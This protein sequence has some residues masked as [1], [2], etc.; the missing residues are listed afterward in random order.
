MHSRRFI[1]TLL[2]ALLPAFALVA[3]TASAQGCEPTE[4]CNPLSDGGVSDIGDLINNIIRWLIGIVGLLA[5]LALIW[6]GM[7][8]IIALNNQQHLDTAKSI[9]KWAIVGLAIVLL[10]FVIIQT[11]AQFA[12]A[13][14]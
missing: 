13:T 2:L 1:A 8:Y 10:S 9:I 3:Y 12:G 14:T 11:V 7:L 6:G 4:F 5:M